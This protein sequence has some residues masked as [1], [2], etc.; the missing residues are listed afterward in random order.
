MGIFGA[1]HYG[2][3]ATCGQLAGTFLGVCLLY[4]ID[5]VVGRT[6]ISLSEF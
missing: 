3:W 6:G 5:P 4:T 1:Y 2:R